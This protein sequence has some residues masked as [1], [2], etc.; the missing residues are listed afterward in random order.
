M[1]IA[2]PQF[3]VLG[4][5]PNMNTATPREEQAGNAISA[6]TWRSPCLLVLN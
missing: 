4:G 6:Q 2:F 1:F 5:V 3:Q